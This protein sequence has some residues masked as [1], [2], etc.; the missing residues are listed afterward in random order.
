MCCSLCW[1]ETAV[2]LMI[3][4]NVV[5]VLFVKQK[6]S[7]QFTHSNDKGIF[8]QFNLPSQLKIYSNIDFAIL[9]FILLVSVQAYA[10]TMS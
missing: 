7:I 10:N 5:F 3:D 9:L 8:V 4:E 1:Q 2:L 6:R